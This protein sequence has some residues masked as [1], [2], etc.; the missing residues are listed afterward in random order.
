[1]LAKLTT[2]DANDLAR[3]LQ[4]DVLSWGEYNLVNGRLI[5]G[6]N[7]RRY[8]RLFSCDSDVWSVVEISEINNSDS[9]FPLH[10]Y[11]TINVTQER[12]CILTSNSHTLLHLL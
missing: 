7:H 11:A 9:D 2:E 10:V 1:M 12:W 6:N 3:V 8:K 4:I 5:L